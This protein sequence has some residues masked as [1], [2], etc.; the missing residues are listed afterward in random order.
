MHVQEVGVLKRGFYFPG[1]SGN[2]P[3]RWLGDVTVG[4]WTCDREVV[5]STPGRNAIKS[6]LTNYLGI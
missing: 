3:F 2:V 1:V 4:R 5:G 6:L